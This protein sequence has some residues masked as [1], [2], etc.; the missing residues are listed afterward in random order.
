MVG[1]GKGTLT[2]SIS[3]KTCQAHQPPATLTVT[4]T[5]VSSPGSLSNAIA[6]ANAGP[7]NV[8]NLIQFAIPP[9]D[10]TF[11]TIALSSSL[12][13]IVRPVII[14]GNSQPNSVTN[15]LAIGNNARILIRI[16]GGTANPIM[17]LCNPLTCGEPGSSDNSIV[18]GLC[19]VQANRGGT[20]LFLG[21]TNVQVTGNFIG[22]DTDG[23]TLGGFSSAIQVSLHVDGNII[24]GTSP[25]ARMPPDYFSCASWWSAHRQCLRGK[26]LP[27]PSPGPRSIYTYATRDWPGRF[28]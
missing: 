28:R 3:R 24:G 2:G 22:V 11:K 1:L 14:D 18:R 8:T 6:Q 10:S 21:G 20:M 7:L 13:D 19:F 26:P 27:N 12:P 17:R 25:A 5:L 4:N 16:N 9:F 23:V 15:S